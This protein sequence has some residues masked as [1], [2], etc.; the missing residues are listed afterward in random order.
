MGRTGRAGAAVVVAATAVLGVGG[1]PAA[2]AALPTLECTGETV[3]QFQ[4]VVRGHVELRPGCALVGARVLGDVRV[5]PGAVR[6]EVLATRVDGSVTVLPGAS[7]TLGTVRVGG[8]VVLQDAGTLWAYVHV[9]GDLRGSAADVWVQ[10]GTVRGAVTLSGAASVPQ[11][12]LRVDDAVVDGAATFTGA[13]VTV[14]RAYLAGG[15]VTEDASR[16]VV[17]ESV[18]H[19]G[20]R[21]RDTSGEVHLG[22]LHEVST[23]Q[24]W[25]WV[26]DGR[27]ERSAYAGRVVVERTG[28]SVTVAYVDVDGDLACTANAGPVTVA[29]TA[30][31]TGARSGQCS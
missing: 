19:G 7:A 15:L 11:A 16:V 31:V 25:Q 23:G 9:R 22:D 14:N 30:T 20:V 1:P 12:A 5:H 6:A 8:D 26:D 10:G 29:T 17:A 28:G 3:Q 2:A 18:V 27:Q 24:G 4:G 13:D 21:V